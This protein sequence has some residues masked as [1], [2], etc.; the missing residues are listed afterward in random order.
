MTT[1]SPITQATKA[2]LAALKR[3]KLDGTLS[4][5]LDDL[6]IPP[7]PPGQI[8]SVNKVAVLFWREFVIAG[9]LVLDPKVW[10]VDQGAE[11][12]VADLIEQM[13]LTGQDPTKAAA[14]FLYESGLSCDLT[15]DTVYDLDK[16]VDTLFRREVNRAHLKSQKV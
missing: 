5:M 13:L 10:R 15:H 6:G 11:G 4:Y 12:V 1:P 2:A 7:T 16:R 14:H 8:W 9:G 3:R